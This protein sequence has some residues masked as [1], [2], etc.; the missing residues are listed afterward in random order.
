MKIYLKLVI[1]IFAVIGIAFGIRQR[2]LLQGVYHNNASIKK[3]SEKMNYEALSEAIE[4]LRYLPLAPELHLNLGV[5]YLFSKDFDKAEKEFGTSAR[6]AQQ[7]D[8]MKFKALFNGGIAATQL[9]NVERALNFYQAS[10]EVK[11]DS[12]EAKTN[13][14][15]LIQSQNGKGK[16]DGESDSKD[17]Q[18]DDQKDDKD[19]QS[20]KNDPNKKVQNE[21]PKNQPQ[22]YKGKE[23]SKENVNKI[24]AELKQQEQNVR[25]KFENRNN[26]RPN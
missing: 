12:I 21:P 20:K 16:G 1:F 13:I 15:L 19:K 4:A 6:L 3:M 17:D 25:A 26:H 18:K 7:N 5:L 11:A 8:D 10:L 9:K 14:E 23:I 2:A 22:P 24:L